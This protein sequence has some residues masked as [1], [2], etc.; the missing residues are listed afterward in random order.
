[1]HPDV[2]REIA[3]KGGKAAHAKG[4][5]HEWTEEEAS[6]AGKKG[7]TISGQ[8]ARERREQRELRES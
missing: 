5:A 8:R 1:M 7:G 3:S 2:Q 4:T 6:R